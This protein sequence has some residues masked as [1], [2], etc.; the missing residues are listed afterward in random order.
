MDDHPALTSKKVED[1]S[2]KS[3][4]GPRKNKRTTTSSR[5]REETA[6]LAPRLNQCK[7]NIT[8]GPRER[9]EKRKRKEKVSEGETSQR[10][11]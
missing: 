8:R 3:R 5:G 7:K 9:V 4:E 1:L 11:H 6:D 2:N 10:G